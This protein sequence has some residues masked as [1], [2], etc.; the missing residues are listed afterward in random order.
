VEFKGLK[1]VATKFIII[2]Y[3]I[4]KICLDEP[5]KINAQIVR[6]IMG[7]LDVDPRILKK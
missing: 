6:R 7:I 2:Q 1:E 3:H 4:G 5:L